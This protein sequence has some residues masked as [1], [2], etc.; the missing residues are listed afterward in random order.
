MLNHPAASPC[1][2]LYFQANTVAQ[3]DSISSEAPSL[4]E[5]TAALNKV[6]SGRAAGPDGIAPELLKCALDPVG[7]ILHKLFQCVWKEGKVPADWRDGM[8]ISLYKGKGSKSDCSSYRPITLLSVPGKVFA[9]V[10]LA[11][12]KPLLYRNRRP[13][14][15]GFTASRGTAD[16]VLALRL[17]AEI[18]REFA[19]PLDVVYVDL[20]AAFDSVDRSALWKSLQG[21]GLPSFILDLIRDLHTDTT[22]RVR[23]GIEQ[24]SRINTSS[25]VRQGCVL[26]PDLFCRAMDWL[27]EMVSP[28]FGINVGE[29]MFSDLDY[30]DDGVLFPIDRARISSALENL[31][32][33]AGHLGLHVSWGKTKVQN[34][35]SGN[36]VPAVIIGSNTVEPVEEFIYLGSKLSSSGYCT[37]EILRRIALAAGAMSSLSRVWR[38]K[39]L[40]LC[41][42]LRIYET[43][44][45]AILLYCAETWT[46]RKIDADRLQAFHMRCLRQIVGVK[47]YDHV[48]NDAVRAT[49]GV[50]D[51]ESR[52]RRRRLALFGHVVRLEPGVPA[53]DA[54]RVSL[55][56][57]NGMSP[58]PSWK[59]PRGRPR[60]AWVDVIQHDIGSMTL[61]DAWMLASDR[62]GWRAFVTSLC[63]S[64]V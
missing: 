53:H 46:L 3:D 26:A 31:D 59:R 38:Q 58:N 32:N 41:T 45:V 42:K 35:G 57:Q 51:I 2:F 11:R 24:S 6:R 22:A 37:P 7:M 61:E 20:K 18:H 25:G 5:V 12:I 56:I 27:M 63:R 30:A 23:T 48:T 8:I 34:L 55:N 47:W 17:L 40:Q 10:I 19:R 21:I 15:S 54:L 33:T 29:T 64:N 43:C 60:K 1:S 16:A 28:D 62:I 52:I 39:R 4:G 50:E 14:Q 9:H 44:V 13:Q 36:P 49:T